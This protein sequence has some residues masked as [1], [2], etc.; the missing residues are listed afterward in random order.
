M[1]TKSREH[2]NEHSPQIIGTELSKQAQ[3]VF[4]SYKGCNAMVR[5]LTDWAFEDL[6]CNTQYISLFIY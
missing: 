3:R 1:F 2:E 5:Q 6:A 4:L